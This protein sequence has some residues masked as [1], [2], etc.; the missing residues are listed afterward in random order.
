MDKTLE[1]RVAAKRK[2]I[3]K[4]QKE[5]SEMLAT[6]THEGF[7]EEKSRYFSGS[8]TDTAHTTYWNQCKLCGAT[9]PEVIKDHGYYG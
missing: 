2:L 4:H 1:Q 9:G 5:L 3:G 8:Y 6:C 7:V